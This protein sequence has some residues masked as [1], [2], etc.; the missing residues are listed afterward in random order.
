MLRWS[1]SQLAPASSELPQPTF[2]VGQEVMLLATK[3]KDKY[4][5]N[6][7]IIKAVLTEK[8]KLTIP[9]KYEDKTVP[10]ESVKLLE[11][12]VEASFWIPRATGLSFGF[13]SPTSMVS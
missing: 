7:Y 1:Q 3:H 10:M 13:L 6:N 4:N 8:L 11:M 2:V 5:K 12:K 9:A